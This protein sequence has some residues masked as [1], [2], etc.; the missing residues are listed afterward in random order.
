MRKDNFVR[1]YK[2]QGKIGARGVVKIKCLERHKKVKK[3]EREG[4]REGFF[5][6]WVG[7]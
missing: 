4:G 1:Q 7:G 3:K 2:D 5:G 6:G